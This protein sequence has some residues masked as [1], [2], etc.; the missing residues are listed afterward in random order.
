VGILGLFLMDEPSREEEEELPP[1]IV[2][3]LNSKKASFD[4]SLSNYTE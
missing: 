4:L 1:Q 3:E 2:E